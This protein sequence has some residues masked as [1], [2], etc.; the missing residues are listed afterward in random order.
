MIDILTAALCSGLRARIRPPSRPDRAAPA[1]LLAAALLVASLA[2]A[3][4]IG[5]ADDVMLSALPDARP[6]PHAG[7]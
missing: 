4:F 1:R 7:R 6:G 5:P 3:L 2:T